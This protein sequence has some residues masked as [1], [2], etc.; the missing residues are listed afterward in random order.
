LLSLRIAFYFFAT[1]KGIGMS[2][3]NK[4]E[5]RSAFGVIRGIVGW[6]ADAAEGHQALLV[7]DRCFGELR[8]ELGALRGRYDE[9]AKQN[10]ALKAEIAAVMKEVEERDKD[11]KG[12]RSEWKQAL[13]KARQSAELLLDEKMDLVLANMKKSMKAEVWGRLER[14]LFQNNRKISAKLDREDSEVPK[15]YSNLDVEEYYEAQQAL[16]HKYEAGDLPGPN[17]NNRKRRADGI[18]I[19]ELLDRMYEIYGEHLLEPKYFTDPKAEERREPPRKA[20]IGKG[21]LLDLQFTKRRYNEQAQ[22]RTP[23]EK[24]P[25]I[26]SDAGEP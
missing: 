18:V 25:F 13:D 10:A 20:K 22:S 19:Q 4:E 12:G 6:V 3:R 15:F 16:L 8:Q 11:Y 21:K 17:D 26:S 14:R 5:Y 7:L 9:Q 1:T 24:S 2:R 23:S